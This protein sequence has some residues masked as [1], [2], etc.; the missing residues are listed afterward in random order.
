LPKLVDAPD[1]EGC[2]ASIADS[3]GEGMRES[4]RRMSWTL[5]FGSWSTICVSIL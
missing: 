3:N 4:I 5:R 2:D 1:A